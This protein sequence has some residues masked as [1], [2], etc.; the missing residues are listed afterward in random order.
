M[1]SKGQKLTPEQRQKISAGLM[2][3]KHSPETIAKISA[4]LN[5][6]LNSEAGER[7][8]QKQ[9]EVMTGRRWSARPESKKIMS[10][11]HKG[12][13]VSDST[14]EA[15][16]KNKNRAGRKVIID[17]VEY[18]SMLAASKA[19]GIDY[20]RMVG[21]CRYHRDEFYEITGHH[22]DWVEVK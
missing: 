20:G 16:I 10:E 19:L 15:L 11:S 17:G 8:K 7:R 2:G 22:I 14:I 3:H 21:Y 4:T 5:A 1:A 13:D 9:S 12:H 6:F 18:K